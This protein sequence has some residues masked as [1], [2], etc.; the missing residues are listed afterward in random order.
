[1]DGSMGNMRLSHE[2]RSV[3]LSD[4]PAH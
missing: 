1:M 3:S 4:G 2:C